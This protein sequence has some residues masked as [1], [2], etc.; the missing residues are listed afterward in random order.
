MDDNA[1][2]DELNQHNIWIKESQLHA[3]PTILVNGY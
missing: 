3:T 1:A 2:I